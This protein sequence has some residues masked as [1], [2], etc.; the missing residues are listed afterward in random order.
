MN[1]QLSATGS[2]SGGGIG[3]SSSSKSS[4]GGGRGSRKV[5]EGGKE[6][7]GGVSVQVVPLQGL[8]LVWDSASAQF[9]RQHR[10]V[11]GALVGTL[12]GFRQQNVTRGL[13][14]VL[15]AEELLL[16]S[17]ANN[18]SPGPTA[19][20][21][22]APFPEASSPVH[23]QTPAMTD[24]TLLLEEPLIFPSS[25]KVGRKVEEKDG[26]NVDDDD[27]AGGTASAAADGG[28]GDDDDDDGGGA[29]ASARGGHSPE[30][31]FRYSLSSGE[32]PF[33]PGVV[34]ALG[35]EGDAV[36]GHYDSHRPCTSHL[37]SHL[38]G[39]RAFAVT[40]PT[41]PAAAQELIG[42]VSDEY[43]R[44]SV[45]Y[46]SS[47]REC[48]TVMAVDEFASYGSQSQNLSQRPHSATVAADLHSRGYRLTDG[49]RFGGNF[50]AYPGDPSGIHSQFVV[51]TVSWDNPISVLQ[52]LGSCRVA[53]ST[54]KRF[55]LAAVRER[56]GALL[57]EDC[58]SHGRPRSSNAC[59]PS[60]TISSSS[61]SSTTTEYVTLVPAL[62][63]VPFAVRTQNPTNAERHV[64]RRLKKG[65][66]SGRLPASAITIS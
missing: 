32:G 3:G 46:A 64:E 54:R 2:S 66:G 55:V 56:E 44:V 35:G 7:G 39:S 26:G 27:G 62:D 16:L 52:L 13:P 14:L 9:L 12:P 65:R 20:A 18:F 38:Y 25:R 28:G 15:T 60:V 30:D 31:Y 5:F 24:R 17:A 29:Q 63:F 49:M 53:L 34:A 6:S 45:P 21:I 48:G 43:G 41:T 11:V 10:G 47:R 37:P 51:R 50:L 22:P 40:A 19:F 36:E 58:P 8:G 42:L 33:L 61:S 23:E 57:L 4:G 1:Q 59:S